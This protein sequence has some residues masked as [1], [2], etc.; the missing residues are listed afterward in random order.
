MNYYMDTNAIASAF[1]GSHQ[2]NLAIVTILPDVFLSLSMAMA[3]EKTLTVY[4]QQFSGLTAPC[5]HI[6]RVPKVPSLMCQN[7]RCE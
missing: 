5:N 6:L 3:L 2:G 7:H 4:T 1:I